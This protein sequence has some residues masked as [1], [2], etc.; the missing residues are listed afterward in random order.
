[1][2]IC[3]DMKCKMLL[4]ELKGE[5]VFKTLSDTKLPLTKTEERRTTRRT[6]KQKHCV[7]WLGKDNRLK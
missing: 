5:N 4:D 3:V 6:R 1:M 7:V 2:I